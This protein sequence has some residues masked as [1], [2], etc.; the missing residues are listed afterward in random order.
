LYPSEVAGLVLVDPE[1]G[2][3]DDMLRAHLTAADWASRQKAMD[4]ALPNM[5][6]AVRAELDAYKKSGKYANEALP[7]PKVPVTL[8]T[9]TKKNPEFPGNPLE[10]DLKLEL[11][12]ALLAKIPHSKHVLV[13][14][15]RHYI[16]ND[17]PALVVEAVRDIASYSTSG[18]APRTP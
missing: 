14:N 11:H 7:L 13:P 12:N 5:P 8:L 4:Q 15:S 16:Q 3:L 17:A 18:S 9:G 1:D 2:R 6:A 10:Q